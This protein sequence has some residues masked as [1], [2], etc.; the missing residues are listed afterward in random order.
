MTDKR[1]TLTVTVLGMGYVGCVS[2]ACLAESGHDVIGVDVSEIKL[3]A[4]TEGRPPVQEPGLA[5][6][7]SQ[8]TASGRLRVTTNVAE[9]V[10]TSDIS[11]ICVGTP[12][13]PH[14]GIDLSHVQHVCRQIGEGLATR[15]AGHV[16]VLR[17]TVVP[18][19]TEDLL[20]P[21]IEKASGKKAGSHFHA[22]FN[23]E[24][25]RES[26]AVSDFRRPPMI[27]VGST[28]P[29]AAD[30]VRRM[31]GNIQDAPF[32]VVAPRVAEMVKY[33]C[34]V[35]HALKIAFANEIGEVCRSAG[36]DSH[37]LINIFLQD[38]QLNVSKAYLRPGFA[39]G[40]SCLP[41]DLK[42]LMH[43]AKHR[44]LSLPVLSHVLES[45]GQQ[46]ERVVQRIL[47]TG[48]RRI[49]LCGLSFKPSTDDLRESP[50]VTLAE[51]LIGKG[52]ELRIYDEHIQVDQL[53]GAN[54]EYMQK[55]LP[56]LVRLLVPSLKDFDSFAETVVIGHRLPAVEAW[57]IHRPPHIAILDLARVE[58]LL[59]TPHYEGISW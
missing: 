32:M 47:A 2:A 49:G 48:A 5:E 38:N 37:S 24:F 12:S 51:A 35:W 31:Y 52:I 3:R 55:H 56:H 15:E 27:V 33:T 44:D 46:V 20:I 53:T 26:S 30:A 10:R 22:A 18:G 54:R 29:A 36:M 19:T 4:L 59:G 41:K 58:R 25:L 45:N 11:L 42:A 14:G 28:M 39:F 13:Q 1:D 21:L 8:A 40:G 23:P 17:S 16:V 34:N 7:I 9:A 43:F 50:F 6:L 57:A